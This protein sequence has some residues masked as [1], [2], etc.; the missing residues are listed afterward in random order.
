MPQPDTVLV[1]TESPRAN[2]G[3]ALHDLFA[4]T[5]EQILEIEAEAQ[6]VE[7]PGEESAAGEDAARGGAAKAGHASPAAAV[8][9]DAR[10]EN[11][12]TTTAPGA[13]AA[14]GTRIVSATPEPP[15]WLAAQM[16]DPWNGET[17]REFWD[18]VQKSQQETAAYR[19][20]FSKPEEARAA[21][22]RARVL[23]DI[24]RAYFGTQ[25]SGPEQARASR[26]QLA[27]MMMREDPAAFREMVFEGLRALEQAGHGTE[28]KSV[29]QAFR[30]EGVPSPDASA[31]TEQ[32]S[33]APEGVSSSADS[34]VRA[35][36]SAAGNEAQLS[37]YAEF[38]RAANQDLEKSVGGAIER[39]LQQAL[40]NGGR[41]ENA[42]L[43][44]RLAATIRQDIEKSLQ[45]D[46]QLGEQVAQVLAGRRLDAET[47]AHVVRL[48]NDRAQQL[49]PVAARRVLSDWTNTT[50]AAHRGKSARADA[51][52]SRREVA[53]S[54]P[55]SA[56]PRSQQTGETVHSGRVTGKAGRFDYGKLSDEQILDM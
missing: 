28:R 43:T 34:R 27:V 46:R 13:K 32:K 4:L 50:L 7:I 26:A 37:A 15:T 1:P 18:G 5:D 54:A 21:A 40:P 6:D 31:R 11:A 17:V 38:E 8:R 16:K 3:S 53:S 2:G 24:D 44:G 35:S 51:A 45:G 47:R 39:R 12:A 56:D 25:G 30:P 42:P 41:A 49:V 36:D 29:A 33:L 55:I 14:E 23:D 19:E 10:N 48:I 22:E 52:S 20:V 9:Q